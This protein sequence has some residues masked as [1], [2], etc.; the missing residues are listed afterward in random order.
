[1]TLEALQKRLVELQNMATQ[2]QAQLMQIGGAI[3]DTQY[4][5]AEMSK[6]LEKSDAPDSVD[7][8]QGV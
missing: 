7:D 8:A 2:T 1:M 5:I 3:Q 4:W 6:S